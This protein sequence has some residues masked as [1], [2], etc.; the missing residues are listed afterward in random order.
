LS[1]LHL[2]SVAM[3]DLRWGLFTAIHPGLVLILGGLLVAALPRRLSA[4]MCTAI[5]AVVV[6]MVWRMS[7]GDQLTHG[8]YGLELTL[9]EVS[10]LGR[11]FAIVFAALMLLA[12][13]FG[14]TLMNRLERAAAMATVG[15]GLGVVLAGDLLSLFLFWEFKVI[16][17]V[18][19][20]AA[21]GQAA[22]S[23]AALRYLRVH[24]LG[25]VIL[26]GGLMWHTARNQSFQFDSFVAEGPGWLMLLGVLF[27]A[28]A[29]PLHSWLPDAYPSATLTGT[30]VLSAITTKSAVYT[31]AR[32]APGV[33]LLIWVG[34]TMAVVGVIFAILEDDIRRLLS[35]HIIS[36][37]GFMVTAIG[38]G[39]TTSINGATAHAA[40]HVLYK[41]LLLM[42]V[43]AVVYATGRSR[44]SGL[45][46]L[47]KHLPWV[48]GLYMIGAF[49]ISGVVGFSGFPAKEL[50]VFAVGESGASIAQWIL[51]FASVGTFLSVALKLPALTWFGE[52]CGP[53]PIRK[54]PASMYIAMGAAALAN[55]AIGL[56]PQILFSLLPTE[57][58]FAVFTTAKIVESSTLILGTTA[59]YLMLRH[60]L[61]PKATTNLDADVVYRELPA[62]LTPKISHLT[63]LSHLTH[64]LSRQMMSAR[65]RFQGKLFTMRP[66]VTLSSS[67]TVVAGWLLAASV[68]GAMV[69]ILAVIVT[70]VGTTGM[71]IR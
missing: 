46:G 63:H 53:T 12:S 51:K 8:L 20:I 36:Q 13:V 65:G 18:L 1:G 17:V 49:S 54:I 41:G 40:A 38:A 66:R 2:G 24:L 7:P 6:L 31:L 30:V 9:V 29:I 45:G 50:A 69:V 61:A 16:T 11:P 21:R 56:R 14:W 32:L 43:G 25:G 64:T 35:Y 68:A 37:V 3:D 67:G 22:S 39:T 19:L 71:T 27:G 55:I 26:L 15:A 10:R 58:T 59:G 52:K 23:A 33:D 34:V 57:E 60:R 70:A 5:S 62:A 28:A 42:A 4:P 48:L 44:L 47:A